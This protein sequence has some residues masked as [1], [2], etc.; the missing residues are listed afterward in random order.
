MSYKE[1]DWAK[2]KS[3]FALTTVEGGRF[4]PDIPPIPPSSVL[5]A[6]LERGIPWAVAT[7][8]EKA[9]SEGIITP[10]LLEVREILQH[11]VSLFSGEEFNVDATVGLNGY[12]DFLISRSTEQL[13]IEAPVIILIEAKQENLKL[14]LGQC[15][16][17]MVAA[18][19]FN[20]AKQQPIA[21]IYG[22]VSTGT[23]WR[24]LKLENQTLTLDLTDYPLPPI[25][26]ILGMVAWM[27]QQD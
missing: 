26:V 3:E 2:A 16:A 1:F 24:F 7:G 13:A 5:L 12:C 11:Q 23:T 9:R 25:D 8:N 14:G 21:T 15:A 27:A 18:Q 22:I 4:L 17:T 20:H 10:L 19:R 6:S